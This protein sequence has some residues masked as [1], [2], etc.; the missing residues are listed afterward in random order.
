MDPVPTSCLPVPALLEKVTPLAFPATRSNR[1]PF[2]L[3]FRLPIRSVLPQR[4]YRLEHPQLGT[5]N[6]FLVPIG[7]D[8]AGLQL[9]AVFN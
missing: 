1:K 9:Q 6:I 2:S 8:Q 3:E 7:M 4:I 5:L